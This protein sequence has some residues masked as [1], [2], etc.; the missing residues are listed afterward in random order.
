MNVNRLATIKICEHTLY[1][2]VIAKNCLVLR[3][4]VNSILT[5]ILKQ[6][7]KTPVRRY[8][9]WLESGFI[10]IFQKK[11]INECFSM[12]NYI[13]RL[14][15]RCLRILF[16][17]KKRLLLQI[18]QQKMG[19]SSH[20]THKNFLQ[21][22]VTKIIKVLNNM[23]TELMQRFF[24]VRQTHY[25]QRNPHHFTIPSVNFVYHGFESISNLGPKIWNLVPD[26]LKELN[27]MNSFKNEIKR[28]QPE[29]CPCRL[30]K[31]YIRCVVFF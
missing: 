2:T 27:S 20:H 22:L 5:I 1:E 4:I 21:V 24:C 29:I 19:L 15:E 23:L 11:V 16:I 17:M 6:L 30:Y 9:F 10:C 8:M 31:T 12:N 25:N 13:N 28:W 3:S 14:H 18:Y 7:L 26:R